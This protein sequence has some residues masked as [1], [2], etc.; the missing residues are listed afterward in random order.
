MGTNYYLMQKSKCPMCSMGHV[1]EEMHIG[2]S[3]AGWVFALRVY[4]DRGINTLYGWLPLLCDPEATIID[5][6][7]KPVSFAYLIMQ[8]TA[9]KGGIVDSAG[10]PFSPRWLYENQAVPGPNGLVRAKP[11]TNRSTHVIWHGEG[12]WDYHVGDFQ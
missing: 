1:N 11:E 5:E 10:I 2:K 3:S 4:P 7:R 9:R 12:T 8:I 6:Y